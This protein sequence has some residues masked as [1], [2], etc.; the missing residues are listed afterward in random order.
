MHRMQNLCGFFVA[1]FGMK[2]ICIMQ[3]VYGTQLAM[4]NNA[5]VAKYVIQGCYDTKCSLF[6]NQQNYEKCSLL[7][8]GT[9]CAK[10]IF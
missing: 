7:K 4:Q 10:Q 9:T 2:R 1:I 8:I 6:S 5:L 3:N